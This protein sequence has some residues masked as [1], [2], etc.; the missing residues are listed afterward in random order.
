MIPKSEVLPCGHRIVPY[1]YNTK[2]TK[3]LKGETKKMID[4]FCSDSG[5][6]KLLIL[7]KAVELNYFSPNGNK[8][9]SI[10]ITSLMCD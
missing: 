5:T 10:K 1:I 6:R 4:R 9:Q 2:F 3:P 7:M 8:L